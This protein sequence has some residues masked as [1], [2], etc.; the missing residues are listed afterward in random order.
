MFRLPSRWH[1]SLLAAVLLLA[2]VFPA[3]GADL[4]RAAPESVGFSAAR[5]DRIGAVLQV[6]IDQK[7]LPGAVVAV[8]RQNKLVY[9]KSFGSIDAESNQSM[10]EDAIFRIASMT[11]PITSTAVMMQIGRASCRERV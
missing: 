4:E 2:T 1:I 11:K 5:L 7:Q 9:L 6:Y 10:R 8:A 3:I